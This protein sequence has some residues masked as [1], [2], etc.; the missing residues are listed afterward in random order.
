MANNIYEKGYKIVLTGTEEERGTI[1]EVERLMEYPAVNCVGQT[2]LGMLAAL[3]KN[4]KMLLSNDTGVSHIAAAVRTPSVVIFLSSDPE[5]W[6]PL[7]KKLHK[8]ILPHQSQNINHV[9]LKTTHMLQL[10]EPIT[11]LKK[12]ALVVNNGRS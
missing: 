8:V 10:K 11:L 3:I 9:L 7:N 6:A 2:N 1:K 4:A 5:R 12:N